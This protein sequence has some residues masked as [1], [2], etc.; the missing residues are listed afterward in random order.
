YVEADAPVVDEIAEGLA[1]A[2]YTSWH[3]TRDSLPGIPYVTQVLNAIADAKAVVIVLSRHALASI[4]VEKEI[5]QAH[6][7]AKSF[8][9]LLLGIKHSE[10]RAHKRDWAM[11]LGAATSVEVPA[12]GVVAIIPRIVQGLQAMGVG[13]GASAAAVQAAGVVASGSPRP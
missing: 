6:E 1:K 5:V 3:Y 9:P 11:M 8:V 10:F 13:P 12:D 4:Q 7:S 2:G